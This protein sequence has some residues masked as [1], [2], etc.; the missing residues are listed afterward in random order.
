MEVE[1]GKVESNGIE[2]CY[3]A[4]GP[5]D[6]EPLLFVMGLSAQMVFWPDS[7]LDRMA[8]RGFRVIRFDNR[9]VGESTRINGGKLPGPGA[10]IT[11]AALGLP[12]R[13]PYTLHDMVADTTGLLDALDIES[14]HWVGASMGGMISQ[15]AAAT[16]PERVRSLTSIMSSTNSRWLPPP[17]PS[18]LKALMAPR[19]R[20]RDEED[21]VLFG[22]QMVRTLGGPMLQSE[23]LTDEIFRRSWRR[24]IYPRGIRQQFMAVLATGNIGGHL[25]QIRCPATVI[26]GTHDPLIR[27]A[28]GRA[29][30]RRIPG[31]RL[32]MIRRMGHDLPEEALPR[33]ADLITETAHH[34]SGRPEQAPDTMATAG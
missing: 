8:G 11:R 26:H 4:R 30:A 16:R 3:E 12:I 15:L 14:A 21:F 23:T 27:P 20:I 34:A 32:S 18:A 9:D 7:L 2:L 6:G 19:V 22:R 25:R 24:G 13:A 5:A 1:S 29:S 33:I 10:L 31:A 17:R 28:G